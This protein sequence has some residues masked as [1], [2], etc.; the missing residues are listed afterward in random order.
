MKL[1]HSQRGVTFATIAFY[2][3][4]LGFVVFTV[5]KLFPVYMD[6]FAVEKSVTSLETDGA[7]YT[8]ALAVRSSLAKRI[9]MNNVS[10]EVVGNDDIS[11]IRENDVYMVE[12]IYEVRVPYMFNID[13]IS[14][15]EL[16][17]EVPAL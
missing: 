15:F 12:V 7:S 4:L 1:Q 9:R 17:A 2:L 5:L 3:A 13:L 6:A 14:Y 11:V 10:S 16:T 8:G